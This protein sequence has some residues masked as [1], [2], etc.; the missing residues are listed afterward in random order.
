MSGIAIEKLG[1][2][3]LDAQHTQH[4]SYF[5]VF[6]EE[7]LEPALEEITKARGAFFMSG[8]SGTSPQ[9]ISRVLV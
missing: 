4:Q 9:K 5:V 1:H 6:S 7:Q 8:I 2:T 3:V